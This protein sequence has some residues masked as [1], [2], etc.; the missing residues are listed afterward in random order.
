LVGGAFGVIDFTRDDAGEKINVM[1]S[2]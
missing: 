2:T 1:V